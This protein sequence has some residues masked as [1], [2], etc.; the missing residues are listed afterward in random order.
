MSESTDAPN[1]SSS[2]SNNNRTRAHIDWSVSIENCHGPNDDKDDDD[3]E[4]DETER[5]GE[6]VCEEKLIIFISYT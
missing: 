2:S 4:D 6:T 5:D 1:S 3:K